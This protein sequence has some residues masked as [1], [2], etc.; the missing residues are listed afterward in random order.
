MTKRLIALLLLLAL[1]LS[2][3]AC[4]VEKGPDTKPH[5]DYPSTPTLPTEK[6]D[7]GYVKPT[8]NDLPEFNS[9]S[10]YLSKEYL[11][12]DWL[13]F[14]CLSDKSNL[15]TENANAA[16]FSLK[17]AGDGSCSLLYNGNSY[18][19]NGVVC[20]G[21][22]IIDDT[23]IALTS[24]DVTTDISHK[25]RYQIST[26]N[27]NNGELT[28]L[29]EKYSEIQQSGDISTIYD[30]T[31]IFITPGVYANKQV[32]VYA[33]TDGITIL[34][35]KTHEKIMITSAF[36]NYSI[37]ALKP[38][39]STDILYGLKSEAYRQWAADNPTYDSTSFYMA[40]ENSGRTYDNVKVP[41]VMDYYIYSGVTGKTYPLGCSSQIQWSKLADFNDPALPAM[42][43]KYHSERDADLKAMGK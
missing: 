41:A 15:S 12:I 25:Y 37:L 39:S 4:T 20:D 23:L 32:A 22:V 24:L 1:A 28:V 30:A 42:L 5:S 18:F 34:F 14:N 27:L 11:N 8:Y 13:K 43:E 31:Q 38:L 36:E 29:D 7:T 2:L 21:Y 16:N 26:I 40:Y 35:L 33:C 19:D 9:L 3:A 10:D 6:P 17:R